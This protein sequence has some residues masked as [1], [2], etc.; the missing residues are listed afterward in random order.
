MNDPSSLDRVL[1]T[2]TRA[3]HIGR[4][5]STISLILAEPVGSDFTCAHWAGQIRTTNA[6]R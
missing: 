3:P 1:D 5:D 6:E 4:T 2:P